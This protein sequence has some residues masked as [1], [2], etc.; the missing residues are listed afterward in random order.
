M[1]HYPEK[2]F[3]TCHLIHLS[4]F[5]FGLYPYGVSFLNTLS[6]GQYEIHPLA[7]SLW[8]DCLWRAWSYAEPTCQCCKATEGRGTVRALMRQCVVEGCIVS[9]ILTK[10][11]FDQVGRG[12]DGSRKA[13]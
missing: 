2:S 6:V 12:S 7:Q 13:H 11:R 1:E 8:N 10:S 5:V 4:V 9:R 3:N